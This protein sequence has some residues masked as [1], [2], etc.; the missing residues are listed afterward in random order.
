MDPTNPN[1]LVRSVFNI[2]LPWAVRIRTKFPRCF[3]GHPTDLMARNSQHFLMHYNSNTFWAFSSGKQ[4]LNAAQLF[5]NYWQYLNWSLY[6]SSP[7]PIF[8][9][10]TFIFSNRRIKICFPTLSLRKKILHSLGSDVRFNNFM[11]YITQWRDTF[12]SVNSF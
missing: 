4:N 1:A 6:W 3:V 7:I 5:L 12:K 8:S 2:C 9:G 10:K 11:P